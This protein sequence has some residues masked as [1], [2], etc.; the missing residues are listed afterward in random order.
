M[1]HPESSDPYTWP[2]SMRQ[3]LDA[4]MSPAVT[5]RR[6][7]ALMRER[8]EGATDGTGASDWFVTGGLVRSSG[9][10]VCESSSFEAGHIASWHPAVALA[11]AHSLDLAAEWIENYPDS[12][13]PWVKHSLAVARTYLGEVPA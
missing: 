10:V 8:A 3:S 1:N 4:A 2:A 11:V 5:I 7:A 13:P 9:G 12:F 6:A